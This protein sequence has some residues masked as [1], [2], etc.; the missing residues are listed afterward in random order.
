MASSEAL[1]WPEGTIHVWTGSATASAVAAYASNMSITPVVGFVNRQTMG[2]VY[3][4]HETGRMVQFQIGMVAS[5]HWTL[6]HMFSSGLMVH[7]HLAHSGVNGSAG[8]ILYSGRI[9]S[10]PFV[11]QEEQTFQWTMAGHANV[12]S[13][14]GG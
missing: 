3:T 8:M 4:N 2:G 13:S 5:Q 10:M 1:V 6:F 7:V 9:D 12:W 14:Y 11:G